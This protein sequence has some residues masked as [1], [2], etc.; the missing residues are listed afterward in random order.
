MVTARFNGAGPEAA[1]TRVDEKIKANIDKIPAGVLPR[2]SPCAAF[3]M[4]RSWC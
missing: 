3:R 2:R 1:A 4:C